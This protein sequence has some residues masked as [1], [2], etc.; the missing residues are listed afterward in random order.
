MRIL[1]FQARTGQK[2]QETVE[3][4]T[5]PSGFRR[6]SEFQLFQPALQEA[7]LLGDLADDWLGCS[8]AMTVEGDRALVGA[9]M[10][11]TA[12]ATDSGSARIFVRTGSTWADEAT[13]PL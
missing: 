5:P 10:S 9:M 12:G 6:H 2:S 7:T 1:A 8:V 3:T 13:W 11:D 4:P